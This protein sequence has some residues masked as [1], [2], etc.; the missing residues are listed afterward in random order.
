MTKNGSVKYSWFQTEFEVPGEWDQN[1]VLLNF[2]AVDYEA[3]VFV[4]VSQ[5]TPPFPSCSCGMKS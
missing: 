3:T 5:I 1:Q 2:Q 4:N